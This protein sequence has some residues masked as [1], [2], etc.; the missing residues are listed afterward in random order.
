MAPTDTRTLSVERTEAL[1]QLAVR[2]DALRA[3]RL[4]VAV[5]GR[6]LEQ[7]T[8]LHA[9]RY[10]ASERIYAAEVDPAATTHIVVDNSELFKPSIV[11]GLP[12]A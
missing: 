5:D 6:T 9:E 3:G 10:A 12:E 1:E 8:H 4:H 2:I 11:R 7:S